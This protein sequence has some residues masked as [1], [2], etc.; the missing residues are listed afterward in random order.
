MMMNKRLS[1][2][3]IM[4][5]SESSDRVYRDAI[6]PVLQK[7][8]GYNILTLRAD[9]MGRS[10][11]TLKAHVENAVK[12]ADFCIADV[13]GGNPNVIYELGFANAVG[14]PTIL[15]GEV[16]THKTLL[17]NLQGHLVI[18]YDKKRLFEFSNKLAEECQRLLI[19]SNLS[20]IPNDISETS[21]EASV[22][23]V[24]D[25]TFVNNFINSCQKKL[26]ASVGS[27]NFLINK[28]MP[29]LL[30]REIYRLDIRVVCANPE[31]EFVRIRSIDSGILV[32]HYRMTLW[33]QIEKMKKL[34]RQFKGKHAELRM[35]DTIVS[36]SFYISDNIAIVMPYISSGKSRE[37]V[38]IVISNN[39]NPK[40]YSLYNDE[41]EKT[42]AISQRASGN[43]GR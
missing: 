25:E 6:V 26:F 20:T 40:A 9:S 36:S 12:S 33:E 24:F 15:I 10:S 27:L 3:I 13:T 31:G 30:S 23:T 29:E 38:S 18:E 4:P 41:F 39:I 16:G 35:T 7:I 1:C 8:P 5:Y 32:S 14:K 2:F 17:S 22:T 37:A 42:W 21:Y 43:V 11:I 34:L 19:T 28:I